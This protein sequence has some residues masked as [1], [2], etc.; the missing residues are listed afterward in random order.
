MAANPEKLLFENEAYRLT[1]TR[2]EQGGMVAELC[3]S[4]LCIT[5]P[6][7]GSR[8]VPL[9][10]DRAAA[11]SQAPRYK[12]PIPVLQAAYAAA[13]QELSLNENEQGLLKAGAAWD[14][15]WTRD[16][17]YAAGL[18]GALASPEAVRR[19][20]ESR[21]RNGIILQ[22]TGTGGGWPVSTDR[23]SWAL[24]AWAYYIVSGDTEWLRTCVDVMQAT[25]AQDADVLP[26]GHVL[27]PGETSFLD[28]REQSYPD[29]M[30]PADIAASYSLSTNVMHYLCRMILTRMLRLLGE[31]EK[32]KRAAMA[33][34]E[35]AQEIHATFWDRATCRYGMISTADGY[36]DD[37]QD[38]LATALM[39]I[40]GLAGE[41]AQSIMNALPRSPF[42]TPVFS[43][44][45]SS[46]PES[47]HNRTIWPFVEAYVLLA[48]AELQDEAGAAFSMASL[49]RAFMA[50]G[51]HKENF[52]AETGAAEGTIQ[53]SDR[54]LWSVCGMLGMV[55]YGLFGMQ[56]QGGNLVFSP[57]VPRAYAG[58]HWLMGV[59]IR[60]MVL[61]I[62]VN[63]YGTE[64]YSVRVNGKSASPILSLDTVGRV[65]VEL[66]LMPA[67][68]DEPCMC[69]PRAKEDL[70][71][72][73]W[74]NPTPTN[75]R[76]LPV[77][78]AEAYCVYRNGTAFTRTTGCSCTISRPE[79]LYY[80]EYCVQ[81]LSSDNASC[82]SKPFECPAPGSAHVLK[83]VRIGEQAEYEVENNQAWLDTKPTTA[84]LDY[85]PISVAAGTYCLRVNYCNAT[86]SLRD[87]D[88]CALREL[89]VDGEPVAVL[90][91]P[92]NT[93]A[94]RWDDYILTAP[95][96]L[97][98]T[99]GTHQFS[100]RYTNRCRNT[101]GE[102]NQCMV[103]EIQLCRLS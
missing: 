64:L 77:H 82:L 102:V 75:L 18:G 98:L 83:P 95:L 21:I 47:Y 12:G 73:Q 35:L 22:D 53:N 10:D 11:N 52:H 42:G 58:S 97:E 39:V 101:N 2:L 94:G 74:D 45:K 91:M 65:Q 99:A 48:H 16:I 26:K 71:E 4:C 93:E 63:G 90:V 30:S 103:R 79:E 7:G 66:E 1:S 100:L 76:W 32:A 8:E 92:H 86:A 6:D 27:R 13:I 15:V 59:R 69:Y 87:A 20:L 25:L 29:W 84:R 56:V 17:A 3:G 68:E 62:H 80:N 72:P 96:E 34:T 55:Y 43:P 38:A 85:E 60:D 54:Q 19:S 67:D 31:E 41:H 89:C 50:F 37:R 33:A 23:V 9:P 57:C 81:A 51:T 14:G 40:S 49:L 28:W 36:L 24:G 61:D 44:Y 78:G 70:P 46:R 5:T 88:T